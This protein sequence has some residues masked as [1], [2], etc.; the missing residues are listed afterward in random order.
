V[1]LQLQWQQSSNDESSSISWNK[2]QL[3]SSPSSND[4]PIHIRMIQIMNIPK[5]KTHDIISNILLNSTL[6]LMS[7]SHWYLTN[8]RVK[9]IV[10]TKFTNFFCHGRHTTWRQRRNTITE[11][12]IFG[13]VW[14]DK[15]HV[16]IAAKIL[17]DRKK[18]SK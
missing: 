2:Y 11:F 7:L 16:I 4:L 13:A 5:T 8:N 18:N 15:A 17:R 12:I 6:L 1:K 10:S 14:V 3:F 9:A